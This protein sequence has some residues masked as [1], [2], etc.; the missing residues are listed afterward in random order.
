MYETLQ[1]FVDGLLEERGFG[2]MDQDSLDDLRAD[3]YSQVEEAVTA[4]FESNLSDEA[5][6]ELEALRDSGDD[7]AIAKFLETTVPGYD[8]ILEEELQRFKDSYQG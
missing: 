5:L 1:E 8:Q 7:D 2:D 4:A 3:V 6:R